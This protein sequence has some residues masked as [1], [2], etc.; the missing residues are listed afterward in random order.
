MSVRATPADIAACADVAETWLF[1]CA[2]PLWL[3]HGVDWRGGGFHEALDLRTLE[4]KADFKRLRVVAR[5]IYV[6]VQAARRGVPRAREAVDH[7][8]QFLF[9]RM[10]HPAGGYVSRCDLAGEIIDPTRDLYDLAFVLFALA[11]AYRLHGTAALKSEAMALLGFLDHAMRHPAGGYVESLPDALPRRQNPHMHLL[12]AALACARLMPDPA[13]DRLCNELVGLSE[14]CFID[15]D[16]G[17]VFEYFASDLSVDRAGGPALVEPGHI[18]EWAW[19]LAEGQR[20]R[21]GVASTG[22]ALAGFALRHGRDPLTGLL[23]GELREDGSI[24]QASV[25]LW[26]HAEWLKAALALG[27]RG[28]RSGRRVAGTSALSRYADA[29]PLARAVGRRGARFL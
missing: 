6:F 14:R 3:D 5:Q 24:S 9:S 13:F 10:R 1:E 19:L 7:G 23:R 21:G 15:A 18:L 25:R 29:R 17:M 11:H 12:E 8:L 20:L 28:G 27:G 4:N 2:I 26:P 16:K 22:E